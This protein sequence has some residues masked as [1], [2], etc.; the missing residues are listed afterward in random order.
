MY[1]NTKI[2]LIIGAILLTMMSAETAFSNS[3]LFYPYV[4][5]PL[6]SW[7]EAVAIGDVNSDGKNDVVMTTSYDFDPANDYHIFVFLQNASGGL[8]LPVK[9]LTSGTYTNRPETITVDDVN[10]DGRTDVVVGN[11]GAN[12]E[13]FLQNNSGL[14]NP[15]VKYP[16]VNSNKIKIGD[17]NNDGLPDVVGIGWGTNTADIFLQNTT[18]TLA[19]PVTYTVTHGG[20]DDLEVGDIN[21]DGLTDIIVMSGQGFAPNVGVLIQKTDRTFNSAIYYD[22]GGNELT[23]GVAVGDVNGDALQDVVVTYGGNKPYSKIGVFLQNN[24]G[25]LNLPVSY[26]SYDIPEPIE[27]AD[28]NQDGRQD[29]VLAHGGWNA[30][31]VYLQNVDG[32]LIPEEL[33]TIPS[34]SYNPHGLAVGDVNGDGRNDVVI[35]NYNNGLIVLYA[36][37]DTDGD[38]YPANIDCDD[39]DPLVNPGAT[40]G[41]YGNATCSDGKDNDCDGL[42]DAVDPNCQS[43]NAD[44][45]IYSLTVPLSG[46]PGSTITVKDITKNIGTDISGAS[47]T[48]FYWSTNIAYDAGDTELASRAIPSLNGGAASAGSTSV[49][50]PAGA[51]IGTYYIIAKADADTVVSETSETNNNKSKSIKI[52]ADLI[53][54]ALTVPTSAARGSTISI[55]DTTKNSGGVTAGTSTTKFYLSTNTTYDAGDAY[56]ASRAIPSLAAGAASGGNTSVIIP[57][58]ITTGTYYIIARA[59]ADNVVTEANESNNNTYKKITVSP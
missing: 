5:Y 10:N 9:Y 18:G 28:V 41:P 2:I 36:A 12:I 45:I 39:N 27:I 59:D 58:G 26:S 30:V 47:A 53:V 3:G 51:S 32:T 11:S 1:K 14:L 49:T 31:G 21:N 23:S 35:A 44:L 19:P 15:S 4:T 50:V 16:T 7:P 46:R 24:T 33:Y 52:G 43:S 29:I 25:T 22:L 38:S 48:K 40:E 37:T 56:L 8:D 17:L 13:V 55:K 34:A 20:R 54:S 42:T 57:S 6:G